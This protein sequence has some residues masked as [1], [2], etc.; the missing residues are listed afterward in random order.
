MV[1]LAPRVT[2]F[3][4]N[5]L[6]SRLVGR[7]LELAFACRFFFDREAVSDVFDALC[8]NDCL[9]T[10]CVNALDGRGEDDLVRGQCLTFLLGGRL[11]VCLISDVPPRR[12]SS[13]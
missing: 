3:A 9:L 13:G 8:K 1:A 2:F 12:A 6:D 10:A 5:S 4:S 11:S 7:A